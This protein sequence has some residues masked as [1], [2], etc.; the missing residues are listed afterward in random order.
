MQKL[1]YSNFYL[2]PLAKVA[3]DANAAA[4]A[5][6][7]AQ[8]YNQPGQPQPQAVQMTPAQ[9]ASQPATTPAQNSKK[10]HLNFC[11]NLVGKLAYV[12]L[13]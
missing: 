4:W 3:A 10:L 6:Y 9:P 2:P 7:Y 11:S 12:D 1:H 13:K 8:F 5:A